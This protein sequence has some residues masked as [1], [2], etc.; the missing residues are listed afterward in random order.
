MKNSYFL[1]VVFLLNEAKSGGGEEKQARAARFNFQ[2]CVIEN[3]SACSVNGTAFPL[4][5]GLKGAVYFCAVIVPS[6]IRREVDCFYKSG[7]TQK[8]DKGTGEGNH[9]H[10]M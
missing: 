6:L 9:A 4:I 5:I 10:E 7:N 2:I 1:N 8:G 3:A